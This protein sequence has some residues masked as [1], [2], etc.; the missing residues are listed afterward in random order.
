[1]RQVLRL[2]FRHFASRLAQQ[3]GNEVVGLGDR[4]GILS[5]AAIRWRIPGA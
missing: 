5:C 3:Y 2:P 4:A 1:M